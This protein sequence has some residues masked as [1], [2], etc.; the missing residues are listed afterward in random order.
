MIVDREDLKNTVTH[1]SS[2][3]SRDSSNIGMKTVGFSYYL[4]SFICTGYENDYVENSDGNICKLSP[5]KNQLS[6]SLLFVSTKLQITAID[7]A[8]DLKIYKS[9]RFNRGAEITV[10]VVA[11]AK[12]YFILT[13]ILDLPSEIY[14]LTLSDS[15]DVDVGFN[16]PCIARTIQG[17]WVRVKVLK[18]QL[19]RHQVYAIDYGYVFEVD[20]QYM[21]SISEKLS[22]IP[23]QCFLCKLADCDSNID[24]KRLNLLKLCMVKLK[25]EEWIDDSV[26]IVTVYVKADEEFKSINH[27]LSQGR[28]LEL[29]MNT[30]SDYAEFNLDFNSKNY[31]SD[32]NMNSLSDTSF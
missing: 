7:A 4:K 2:C 28:T 22:S 16:G 12:P 6:S 24:R 23:A 29:I 32:N 15:S 31:S 8:R 1:E 21:R 9:P 18:S 5:I 25:V 11:T 27:A 19:T 30:D 3:S 26:A 20:S 14:D 13:R 10:E 17:D